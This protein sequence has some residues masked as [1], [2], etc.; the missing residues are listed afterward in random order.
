MW[1][2]IR[3]AALAALTV[4][5]VLLFGGA[6]RLLAA[7][8]RAASV[9][10]IGPLPRTGAPLSSA[11]AGAA[12]A[13]GAGVALI[14]PTRRVVGQ[15]NTLL[16]EV[17]HILVAAALGARPSGIVLRHDA[18]GH[19]TARWTGRPGPVRRVS[20]AATAF[21]GLPAPAVAAAAGAALLTSVGPRAVLWSLVGAGAVVTVL[22]RSLWSLLVALGLA[23]LA[24]V[25][26]SD[27]AEP[28]AAGLAVGV[29]VAVAVTAVSDAARRLQMP[30]PRGD[31]ARAVR[32]Q[33][34]LA[35]RLVQALQVLAT[36]AAGAWTVWLLVTA[37][38]LDT[39]LGLR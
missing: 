23:G 5:A 17:G 21:V 3:L 19:A 4:V 9:G 26:L 13:A 22:A 30:I 6:E 31:D 2:L 25:A 28:W 7:A 1:T 32:E 24:V 8:D 38:G 39:A 35:P 34:R 36:A 27:A 33:L 37:A 16:H 14:G 20:L 18:S 29:V 10:G 11:G 12:M 15:L